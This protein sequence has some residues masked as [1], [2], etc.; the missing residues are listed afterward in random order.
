[1]DP[2]RI[3]IVALNVFDTAGFHIQ[4]YHS[5]NYL[6]LL[7]KLVLFSSS[8][9]LLA[10]PTSSTSSSSSSS[11]PSTASTALVSSIRLLGVV[12]GVLIGVVAGSGPGAVA[13]APLA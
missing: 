4:P 10:V 8:A 13:V 1:M 5:K 9:L 3:H 6:G 11:S 7:T 2:P 12:V